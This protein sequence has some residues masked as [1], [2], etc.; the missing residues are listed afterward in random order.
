MAAATIT[1]RPVGML[2]LIILARLLDPEDFGTVA[3]AMLLVSTVRLFSGMGMSQALIQSRLE[4]HTVAFQSFLVTCV[5]SSAIFLFVNVRPDLFARFLGNEELVPILR[6][7]SLLILLDAAVLIPQALLSKEMRFGQ[8]SKSLLIRNLTENA[9]SVA[10][11]LT[12][13]GLW[14]LV[15]GRLVGAAIRLMI[16]WLA[17]T[18]WVWIRPRRI[19]WHVLRDMLKYGIKS[20]S[21]G[22]MNFVNSHWDDWLVGRVLGTAQ[23]GFYSRAYFLTNDTIVGLNRGVVDGVLFP[24]YARMQDDRQR[25]ARAYLKSLSVSALLMAPLAL[26]VLA[27][28]TE[29][30]PL[31]LGEKW[32]PMTLTLQIF[33][34]MAFF[35]PLAGSTGAGLPCI[36]PS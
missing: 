36:G 32:I 14:S 20:S 12:G 6:W 33:S 34:I 35:R 8:V 21:S 1:S 16:V 2:A 11:A 29:L 23:L 3:L 17:C 5:T 13:I 19:D 9:V 31:L 25:L 18:G 22:M 7:L 27:L 4:S 24:S 26:G 10:L 30:V 15:W 28:S